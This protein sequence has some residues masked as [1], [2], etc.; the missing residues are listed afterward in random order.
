M[1]FLVTYRRSSGELHT[2][3]SFTDAAEA[4]AR[5]S[6]E[7]KKYLGERADVEVALFEADD[8][9][10]FRRTHARYFE[11]VASLTS[12]FRTILKQ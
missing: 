7:T 2:F 8:E 12:D 3:I 9:A 5:L 1:I 11:D 10:N 4:N 6:E